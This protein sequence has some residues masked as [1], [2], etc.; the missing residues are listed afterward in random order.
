MA[1]CVMLFYVVSWVCCVALSLGFVLFYVVLWVCCVAL[2][3]GG[4]MCYIDLCFMGLV[5]GVESG[6][7]SSVVKLE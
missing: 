5:C 6:W 4:C 2:S 1:V 7:P 3:L